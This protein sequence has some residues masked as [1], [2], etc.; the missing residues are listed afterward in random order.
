MDDFV[1]AKLIYNYIIFGFKYRKRLLVLKLY[2]FH[3]GCYEIYN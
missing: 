3:M 1:Y 2:A